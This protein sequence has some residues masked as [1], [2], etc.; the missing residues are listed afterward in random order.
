[1]SVPS[2]PV[3]VLVIDDD[4]LVRTGIRLLL[5]GN[6]HVT[7]V[8]ELSGHRGA[9]EGIAHHRPDVLLMDVMMPEE[10]GFSLARRARMAYPDL[11]IVL[12]SSIENSALSANARNAG[13]NAFIP[14][15]APASN[16]IAAIIGSAPEIRVVATVLSDRELQVVELLAQGATNEQISASLHLS[17]NTVKTYISRS[18][19]KTGAT[20][21]VQLS[22][23]F[24]A[25]TEP[26]DRRT[27][28]AAHRLAAA[29]AE[30]A[31]EVDAG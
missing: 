31:G 4:P 8:G 28:S 17:P 7:I 14:K 19:D 1:M 20:N 25:L 5:R 27:P 24:H 6:V 18:M 29:P 9:L 12:M 30:A 13:V 21:R 2:R 23:W 26:S 11:R 10:S 16:F 15:T 22:N 3:R